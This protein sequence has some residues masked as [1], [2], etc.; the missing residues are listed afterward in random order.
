MKLPA[1]IVITLALAACSNEQEQAIRH[2]V[3]AELIQRE[4][5]GE[6]LIEVQS[7]Q[8]T[9]PDAVEVEARITG[10]TSRGSD[11]RIIHCSLKH[12]SQRWQIQRLKT[13]SIAAP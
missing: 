1:F 4:H 7:I 10:R 8:F 9:S 11:R 3:V 13:E 6:N 2:L 5:T 12:D